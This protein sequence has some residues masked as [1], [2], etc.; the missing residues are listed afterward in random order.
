M[1]PLLLNNRNLGL[2][3]LAVWLILSGLINLIGL[4]FAGLAIL[5]GVLA[6]IAGVLLILGK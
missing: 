1:T 5:M 3:L 4:H 2:M 6:I